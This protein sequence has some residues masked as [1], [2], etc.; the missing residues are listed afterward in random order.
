MKA[1]RL[2]RLSCCAAV[3]AVRGYRTLADVQAA[4]PDR[5]RADL[6]I[7]HGE[8]VRLIGEAHPD[9]LAALFPVAGVSWSVFTA[10]TDMRIRYLS[11]SRRERPTITFEYDFEDQAGEREAWRLVRSAVRVRG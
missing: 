7:W 9:T 8:V 10:G 4:T 1:E 5:L 2:Y 11:I 6:G 3:L